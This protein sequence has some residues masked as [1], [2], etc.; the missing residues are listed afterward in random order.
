[1]YGKN[2]QLITL[3]CGVCKRWVALRV[4]PDDLA[5]HLHDGVLVQDALPYLD[6][7]TRELVLS[8]VCS[9]CW[10]LLCPNPTAHPF[11]YNEPAMARERGQHTWQARRGSRR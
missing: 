1:M 11:A 8:A 7:S 2:L 3:R 9:R 4:D 10:D 6:A 5:R